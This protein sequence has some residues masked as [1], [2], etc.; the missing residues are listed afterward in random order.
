[1]GGFA[2]FSKFWRGEISMNISHLLTASLAGALVCFIGGAEAS[3]HSQAP[4][5]SPLPLQA[6]LK[7]GLV[8]GHI[9]CGDSGK[10][11][12]D[13]ADDDD[14]DG[15]HD[16][17]GDDDEHHKKKNN[18]DDDSGLEHCT[19][20]SSKGGGGCVSPYKHVCEKLKS[21]KKCCGC[22]LPAGQTAPT[23][24]A[25]KEKPFKCDANILPVDKGHYQMLSSAPD[26]A[27]MRT[28]FLASI[29]ENRW[30]LNGPVTC[31]P[32]P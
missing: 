19:I 3:P 28:K 2:S 4:T 27:A 20:Q 30:T 16:H 22:V 17:N 18:S 10:N 1:M 13:D 6:G 14:D 32:N 25:V 8:N 7:C 9:E 12:Q 24:P 26:E 21:G 29:A 5:F 11:H 31:V 15:D 23:P